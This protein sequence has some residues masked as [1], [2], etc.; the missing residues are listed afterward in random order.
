MP[1]QFFSASNRKRTPREISSTCL[2][3]RLDRT[4]CLNTLED[5][6]KVVTLIH[7]YIH[8]AMHVKFRLTDCSVQLVDLL[9]FHVLVLP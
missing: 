7:T 4:V 9:V 5:K 2:V 8:S 1:Y 6:F 3:V